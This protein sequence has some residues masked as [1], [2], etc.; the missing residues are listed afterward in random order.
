[1]C[2]KFA[3]AD[4]FEQTTSKH[5]QRNNTS[6][7]KNH[8]RK[9]LGV[10]LGIYCQPIWNAFFIC[11]CLSGVQMGLQPTDI[12]PQ[13]CVQRVC[14][15]LRENSEDHILIL[16]DCGDF[17]LV[18]D[19][20]SYLLND[21]G[22]AAFRL[23]IT[24]KLYCPENALSFPFKTIE[25]TGFVNENIRQYI[26]K[27]KIPMFDDG[28]FEKYADKVETLTKGSPFLLNFIT[29][30]IAACDEKL[31]EYIDLREFEKNFPPIIVKTFSDAALYSAPHVL[32][33]L[34]SMCSSSMGIS[35]V[36]LFKAMA[37]IEKDEDDED[38]D[39]KKYHHVEGFIAASVIAQN[40]ERRAAKPSV[41]RGKFKEIV[42]TSWLP[43]F[44]FEGERVKIPKIIQQSYQIWLIEHF[45]CN[46]CLIAIYLKFINFFFES[47]DCRKASDLESM[48][49]RIYP[50]LEKSETPPPKLNIFQELVLR[51]VDEQ[52]NL[53]QYNTAICELQF[54]EQVYTRSSNR[55]NMRVIYSKLAHVHMWSG[56][57]EAAREAATK[58]LECRD[59][60]PYDQGL[61]HINLACIERE[62]ENFE[63]AFKAMEKAGRYMITGS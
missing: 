61:L 59:C 27:A 2:K 19:I 42:P 12:N 8:N 62:T 63:R 54:L 57:T 44:V 39:L 26:R 21:S 23:I 37:K 60:N 24:S 22:Q 11:T 51:L 10:C 52:M 50:L 34:T 17:S 49:D 9:F 31:E 5:K 32:M 48:Y 35:I 1:M 38:S 20:R 36:E 16:D 6:R 46:V 30:R 41:M 29:K 7:I 43:V 55:D 33:I 47:E 45:H 3:L 13:T 25:I 15:Y 18:D 56:N 4:P 40:L 53:M 28:D 58:A 14:E